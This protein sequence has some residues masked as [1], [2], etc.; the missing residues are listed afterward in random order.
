MKAFALNQTG[1]MTRSP[2][3]TGTWTV[4]KL[5]IRF[6]FPQVRQISIA[7][8]ADWLKQSDLTSLVL[9]DTRTEPEFAVSHLLGAHRIEPDTTDFS[10]L[11]LP[12]DTPIVA[13]CSVGYRS[14]AL[15]DRLQAAGFNQVMNLEG[16]IFA[17]ANVGYPVYQGETVVQQVHPC[18]AV[19]GRLLRRELHAYAPETKEE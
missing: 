14:A 5:L 12:P 1:V 8:L 15:S 18:N 3:V 9:L 19:W 10:S 7:T 13:Y 16:S 2:C 17:W 11:A 4:L 6:R